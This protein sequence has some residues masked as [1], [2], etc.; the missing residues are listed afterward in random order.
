[1]VSSCDILPGTSLWAGFGHELKLFVKKASPSPVLPACSWLLLPLRGAGDPLP[2][3][4]AAPFP[5]LMH[6]SAAIPQQD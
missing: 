4:K 1:M 6:F 5:L 3:G 2:A